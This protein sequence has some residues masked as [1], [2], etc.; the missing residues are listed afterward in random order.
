MMT[1][2]RARQVMSLLQCEDVTLVLFGEI[3]D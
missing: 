3:E 2:Q 1:S